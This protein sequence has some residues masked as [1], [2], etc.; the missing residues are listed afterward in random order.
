MPD[1]Y[2]P[3]I[4]PSEITPERVWLRRRELLA[5]AAALGLAG[6]LAEPAAA[7]AL[8]TVPSSYSTDEKPTS[9]EDITHYNNFYEFGTGKSDPAEYAAQAHHPARGPSRS[10]GWS[11]SPPTT[12]S[13]TSWARS[14]SR[15]ASIG[16]RCVE[17]LVDGDP[18]GRLS[19]RRPAQAR[20]APGQ[21]QVRRLRDAAAAGGDAGSVASPASSGPMSRGFASTR[22]CTRSPSSPSG[23]TARR[24]RIRTARR[25]G[26]S[27]RGSTASR[28]SSRS[29]G[30]AWSR[31]CRRPP[32]TARAPQR[33]RLLFQREPARSTTRA[34]ARRASAASARAACSPSGGKTLPF[35]GYADQVAS[36]YTGMDLHQN[37]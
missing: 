28:A 3:G 25:S 26:W 1:R 29:S 8:S 32:G 12:S 36:L 35:N 2:A 19:A 22:R 9:L 30:S 14:R 6:S 27:C 13:R 15:S 20:R 21:R 34:G 37:Y 24:C 7:E 31:S 17:G 10:T 11:P 18:L 5:G 4:R 33:V 23:S 16:M